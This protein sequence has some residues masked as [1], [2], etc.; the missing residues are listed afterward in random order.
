[1]SFSR[2]RLLLTRF[3]RDAAGISALEFAIMAPVFGV[4]F[5]GAIDFGGVVFTKIGLDGATS[6]AANYALTRNDQ[7]TAAAGATLAQ[8]L[9][10]IVS[11]DSG[12]DVTVVVNNGPSHT[13]ANG[14]PS[15]G[16]TAANADSCYCPGRSGGVVTWGGAVTCGNA[17]GTGSVAGKFVMITASNDYT[18][19]FSDYGIVDDGTVSLVTMV[20]TQ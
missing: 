18:P 17:C 19:I 20:Q 14:A 15:T 16:G 13:I 1:M 5:A 3:G 6:A 8:T 4:V 2:L 11:S 12:A 9:A 10:A 7:V